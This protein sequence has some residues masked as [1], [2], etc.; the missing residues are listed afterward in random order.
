MKNNTKMSCVLTENTYICF[1][2]DHHQGC[3]NTTRWSNNGHFLASGGDDKVV[4][5]WQKSAF[6]GGSIFGGGGKV[7]MEQ[8]RL[9]KTLRGHEGDVLDLAWG[10][11]LPIT[12]QFEKKLQQL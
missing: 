3:V 1:Q 11:Y 10:K 2:M 9:H 4:M 5:L 12:H 7:H 6:S 8:W